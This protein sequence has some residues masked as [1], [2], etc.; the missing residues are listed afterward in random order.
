M[1]TMATATLLAMNENNVIKIDPTPHEASLAKSLHV[2]GFTSDEDLL[3]VESQG[4]FTTKEWTE[5]LKSGLLVCCS[6]EVNLGGNLQGD[7]GA[8]GV[9]EF[10]RRTMET[11]IQADMAWK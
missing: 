11:K 10:I 3:L 4:A 8:T 5:I 7:A 6:D 2:L 1:K 9:R